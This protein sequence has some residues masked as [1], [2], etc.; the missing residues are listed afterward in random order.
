MTNSRSYP[1]A[2][3]DPGL[4]FFGPSV[5]IS[6]ARS[7]NGASAMAFQV[8]Q[9]KRF[10]AAVTSLVLL[11]ARANVAE[12]FTG[13]ELIR[14]YQQLAALNPD[15]VPAPSLQRLAECAPLTSDAD[16]HVLASALDCHA[17]YLL[18]LDRRRLLTPTVLSARLPLQVIT[19]GDFLRRLV[20][21]QGA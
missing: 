7:M 16:A 21:S 10:R 8:C 20:D 9:G 12:Q 11:E 15:I 5:L 4:V 13:S 18:T 2:G 6:V 17:A 3:P 1:S 19:P 14:F